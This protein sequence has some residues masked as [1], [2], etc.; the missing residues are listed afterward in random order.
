MDRS[1]WLL[2]MAAVIRL[3]A[4]SANDWYINWGG[5][6]PAQADQ[7]GVQPLFDCVPELAEQVHLDVLVGVPPL[8]F[9]Q[10]LGQVQHQAGSAK[11]AGMDQVQVNPFPNDSFVSGLRWT[12]QVGRSSP[13]WNL[14]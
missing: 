2:V 5:K 14:P 12:Y 4:M 13:A 7:A 1:P 8:G 10:S 3:Q 9:Q 6:G 11:V